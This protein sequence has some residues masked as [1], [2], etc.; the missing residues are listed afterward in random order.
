MSPHAR[1]TIL[2]PLAAALACGGEERPAAVESA[3][4]PEGRATAELDDFGKDPTEAHRIAEG[5]YH[6]HGVGNTGFV[7][8]SEG[9]VVIDAGLPTSA[10]DHYALMREV[11]DAPVRYAI[12]T[13]A[14][15]DHAG[16]IETFA[17]DGTEI[18]A[19]AEFPETQRYLTE[20]LPFFMPKNKVFYPDSVVDVPG[21]AMG[22]LRRVYPQLEPT[23]LVDDEYVFELGGVRFE[24]LSTPS[25]EGADSVSVWLPQ[26][27]ILFTG[28]FFGPIFPMVPNLYTIR[29]EKFRYAIPY[30]ESLDKLIALEP[31][32]LVP[33]HFEPI[34]GKERIVADM[35]KTR[36]AVQYIHDET[37][38]GMNDGKDVYTLMREIR[39]PPEL[40][41]PESHGKVA[42]DVRGIW[43][44]YSGWFHFDSTAQ[45]YGVPPSSVHPEIVKMAGGADVVGERAQARVEAGDPVEALHLVEM[46][47]AAD[48]E[49]RPALEAR[50]AALELLLEQSVGNHSEVFWLRHRI[51]TTRNQL[52]S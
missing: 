1:L 30:I 49:S 21:W 45:L 2:L 9:I 51:A 7:V 37:V 11:S 6:V 25:A 17:E 10:D 23:V 33:S 8:T 42:W 34:E 43:E 44:G 41:L 52:G 19:H 20:L 48:P 36:D 18:I 50:L 16:G 14:H 27:K 15:A 28:D 26:Q 39:L 3:A 47:L 12:A 46:A 31:E 32:M 38:A 40:A 29:G 5:V 24:V 35:T 13:H 4:A 22:A